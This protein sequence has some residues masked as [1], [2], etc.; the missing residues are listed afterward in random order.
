MTDMLED[1][2]EATL[3]I[4]GNMDELP[5]LMAFIE[6]SGRTLKLPPDAS[7]AYQL[8]VEEICTNLIKYGYGAENDGL[9]DV[10]C[11]CQ[12]GQME[13]TIRDQSPPYDIRRAPVPDT[14]LPLHERVPGGL[15]V[16]LVM[17]MMDDVWYHTDEEGWNTLRLIKRWAV[18]AD[19]SDS[20]TA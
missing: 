2:C 16:Y 5:R 9:I 14:D 3:Q 6:E 17:R 20:T 13:I 18:P 7:Y 15:G 10:T 8:A 4:R 12:P 11:R 19:T 1:P